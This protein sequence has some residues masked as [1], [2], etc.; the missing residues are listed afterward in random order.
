[1]KEKTNFKK[2][3]RGFRVHSELFKQS[4]K[5]VY[6]VAANKDTVLEVVSGNVLVSVTGNNAEVV[7]TDFGTR[8]AVSIPVHDLYLSQQEVL[9]TTS[10]LPLLT[11]ET[12]PV[13]ED[14]GY[15]E[16]EVNEGRQPRYKRKAIE[17]EPETEIQEEEIIL[18]EQTEEE[19]E[20]ESNDLDFLEDEID[21]EEDFTITDGKPSTTE[22]DDMYE[23]MVSDYS[24]ILP[25]SCLA[26]LEALNCPIDVVYDNGLV[27]IKTDD[28]NM[29]RFLSPDAENFPKRQKMM[30]T[31]FMVTLPAEVLSKTVKGLSFAVGTD[32]LRPAMMGIF[33][34]KISE[35]KLR[36]VATNAHILLYKTV[37]ANIVSNLKE[38]EPVE[39]I[40][41]TMPFKILTGLTGNATISVD[42]TREIIEFEL[43]GVNIRCSMIEPN[44]Y[45]KYKV[46]LPQDMPM[47][48]VS[49]GKSQII[50]TLKRAKKLCDIATNKLVLSITQDKM[51]LVCQNSANT[52]GEYFN[53]LEETL[54]VST[55][56]AP[57]NEGFENIVL[58]LNTSLLYDIICYGGTSETVTLGIYAPNKGV[59][60]NK[61]ENELSLIMPMVV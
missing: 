35:R 28:G 46:V 3:L 54:K 9:K 45:P 26:V 31:D 6:P 14:V 12:F 21:N 53:S 50:S 61:N 57:G 8:I 49:V 13:L 7:A 51:C 48:S 32:N 15:E 56:L 17:E 33:M 16:N 36:L 42:V 19:T 11:I 58:G 20:E 39:A 60:V 59:I 37:D 25:L 41:P 18:D 2:P 24:F 10:E 29:Y 44:T 27:I 55:S 23:T 52:D 30:Q 38:G 47:V 34:E 4:L 22:L 1:M 5:R 40:L 43:S